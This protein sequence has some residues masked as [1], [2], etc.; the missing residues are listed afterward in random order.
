MASAKLLEAFSALSHTCSTNDPSFVFGS[1]QVKVLVPNQQ[2]GL[3]SCILPCPQAKVMG[4]KYVQNFGCQ[5]R[6]AP[7]RKSGSLNSQ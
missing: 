1:C 5:H 6:G 2:L 7:N 3:N 4:L